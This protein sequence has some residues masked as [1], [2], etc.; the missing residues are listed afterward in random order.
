MKTVRLYI[1]TSFKGPVVK[2]G[3][4]AAALVFTKADGQSAFRIISGGEEETTCNRLTLIAAERALE[5][6]KEKCHII[7]YTDNLYVKGMIE[8]GNPEK[9]RRAEWKKAAGGEVQNKELWQTFLE[10]ADK[11]E[12]EMRFSKFNEFQKKLQVVMQ[13]EETGNDGLRVL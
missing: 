9:W 4:Y 12:I 2:D 7:I 6:M 13:G 5:R 8:Q 3:K 1:E 10:K 11:Q